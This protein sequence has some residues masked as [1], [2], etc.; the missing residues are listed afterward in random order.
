MAKKAIFKKEYIKKVQDLF[1]LGAT[2]YDIAKIL[3]TNT[4][5]VTRWREAHPE[6]DEVIRN[7]YRDID[8]EVA[9]S[10]LKRMVGYDKEEVTVIQ[11][12]DSE[13]KPKG[14]YTVKTT[15]KHYPP[16]LVTSLNWLKSRWPEL[17]KEEKVIEIEEENEVDLDNQLKE[18]DKRRK[19]LDE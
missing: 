9:K 6:F 11:N 10:M 5:T 16:D 15:N 3:K 17:F 12:F 13:G 18:L 7:G 19:L 4:S 8:S 1:E 14:D 2:E